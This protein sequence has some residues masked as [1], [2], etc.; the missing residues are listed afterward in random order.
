VNIGIPKERRPFEYRAGLSPAGVRL[1]AE[2][3]HVC[4]LERG[5]GLGAGF[6]D[7]EYVRAGARIAYTPEETWGRTQLVLKVTRP[8]AAELGWVVPG[9]ILMGFLYLAAGHPGKAALL[10]EKN[11]TAIAYELIQLPDGSQPVLK[12][13]SQIGGRM[14]LHMAGQAL[15]NDHGGNGVLL[16]SVPGVAPA[17]VVIIGGGV[18]GEHAARAFLGV[19]SHVTILDRDLARLQVLAEML[20]G[21][22]VTLISHPFNIERSCAFADVVVGAVAVPGERTPV[23]LT[24]ETL[25]RMRPGSVFVDVSIDGGGCAETSRPTTHLSPSYVEEGVIH[26]CVPNLPGV[27]ART[28]THA[29]LN[30]AWPYIQ[31]VADAGADEAIAS[32]PALARGVVTHRG[33]ASNLGH[34]EYSKK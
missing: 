28:S 32:D 6:T 21:R 10:A 18:A 13:L 4:Y 24:R 5:A 12:P 27:V 17:E 23:V 20:P 15:R 8:T 16:G 30:A 22:L 33:V 11:A 26:V 1:L 29:F 14:A 2:A 7:E 25:R 9:Q 34:V 19:G 3:G 31:R